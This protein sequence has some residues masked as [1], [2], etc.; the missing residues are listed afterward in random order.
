[1]GGC[2]Q[3][4]RQFQNSCITEVAF[5][6]GMY[7]E[8]Q[9]MDGVHFRELATSYAAVLPK[10]MVH[11]VTIEL[12]HQEDKIE[13][14]SLQI[15]V[16]WSSH[17]FY[18]TMFICSVLWASPMGNHSYYDL[19][20]YWAALLWMCYNVT[21]FFSICRLYYSYSM[22]FIEPCKNYFLPFRTYHWPAWTQKQAFI[23]TLQP[24]ISACNNWYSLQKKASLI[25]AR[26]RNWYYYA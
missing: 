3:E 21:A 23:L 14:R 26:I 13:W 2:L 25:S 12:P 6:H 4:H 5:Q 16:K 1:M 8:K 7:L 18:E 19:R 20:C 10:T 9:C 11:V 15:G 24:I 17:S 22:T